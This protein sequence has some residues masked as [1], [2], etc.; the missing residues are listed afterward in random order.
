MFVSRTARKPA[1]RRQNRVTKDLTPVPSV[2]VEV[3]K[4]S[5]TWLKITRDGWEELW[6]SDLASQI[7]PTDR[8]ALTRLYDWRDELERTRRQMRVM[9]REASKEPLVEGSQGQPVRNPMFQVLDVLMR[10]ALAIEARIVALEDRL[11]LSPKAR[12]GLGVTQQKGQSLAMQNARI[13]EA[14]QEA[15]SDTN[16]PRAV[17]GD[18]PASSA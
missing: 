11:G 10:S 2:P 9:T 1:G 8:P 6:S 5:S 12:L 7:L 16:D 15:M 17:S 18:S 4:P 3:P 13:A 14:L